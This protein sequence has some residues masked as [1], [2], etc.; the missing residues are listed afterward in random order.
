M[1]LRNGRIEVIHLTDNP[2]DEHFI[3]HPADANSTSDWEFVLPS[4]CHEDI[5]I[6]VCFEILDKFEG[7]LKRKIQENPR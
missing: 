2:R 5:I 1:A 4:S 6:A 7:K 3:I